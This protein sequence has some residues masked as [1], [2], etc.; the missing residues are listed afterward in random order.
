MAYKWGL[1]TTYWDDPPSS[2]WALAFQQPFPFLAGWKDG[3]S[4][5]ASGSWYLHVTFF[6]GFWEIL[7]LPPPRDTDLGALIKQ[8]IEKKKRKNIYQSSD[9]WVPCSFLGCE[10]NRIDYEKPGHHQQYVSEG[11]SH[12]KQSAVDDEVYRANE[13]HPEKDTNDGH[14]RQNR[15]Q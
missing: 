12:G 1:L 8:P 4:R 14:G 9:F 2:P 13:K 7:V 6:G 15:I 10:C 3:G 11:N 5:G